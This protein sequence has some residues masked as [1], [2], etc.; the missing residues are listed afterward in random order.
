MSVEISWFIEYNKGM[1]AHTESYL[2]LC[3][4]NDYNVIV[5]MSLM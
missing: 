2:K 4:K 3:S 5:K 1:S